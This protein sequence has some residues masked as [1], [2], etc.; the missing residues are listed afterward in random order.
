MYTKGP[1]LWI[2][3]LSEDGLSLDG[4]MCPI[5]APSQ[6]YQGDVIEAPYLTYHSKSNSYCLFYSSGNF[7]TKGESQ[8]AVLES[9]L[10]H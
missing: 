9:H 5:Q 7:A 8:N 1:Q 6:D 10:L 4:D 2:C 3:K